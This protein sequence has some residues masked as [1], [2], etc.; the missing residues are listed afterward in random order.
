MSTR[1][2]RELAEACIAMG[3]AFHRLMRALASLPVPEGADAS[4][5]ERQT[6]EH[7]RAVA[8]ALD[9]LASHIH[10]RAHANDSV[11]AHV[12]RHLS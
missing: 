8:D 5:V 3:E 2:R 12:R 6:L 7:A 10:D 4:E 11:R 1:E 9:G